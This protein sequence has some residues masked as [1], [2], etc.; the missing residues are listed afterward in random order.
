MGAVGEFQR[1]RP[2]AALARQTC[3]SAGTTWPGSIRPTGLNRSRPG[4]PPSLD[5]DSPARRDPTPSRARKP[6]E[7]LEIPAG[8]F[9]AP[10]RFVALSDA[11]A[12]L[13]TV[14]KAERPMTKRPPS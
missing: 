10:N 11:L 3:S 6:L 12:G 2:A 7:G 4:R 1:F 5:N 9:P 8:I 14:L 13:E